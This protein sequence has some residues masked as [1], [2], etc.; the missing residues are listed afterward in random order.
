MQ[1]KYVVCGN[2]GARM[3]NTLANEYKENPLLIAKGM[4]INEDGDGSLR[5]FSQIIFNFC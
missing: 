4:L 3:L 2:N 5:N 1:P